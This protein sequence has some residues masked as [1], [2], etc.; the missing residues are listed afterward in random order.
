MSKK[1]QLLQILDEM[2]KTY[3]ELPQNAMI[4]PVTH[5]DHTSLLLLIRELFKVKDS[6]IDESC[7]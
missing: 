2:I 6:D 5:Y 1:A 3:E 7:S 4:M